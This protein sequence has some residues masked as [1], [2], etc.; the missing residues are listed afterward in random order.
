MK[1]RTLKRDLLGNPMYPWHR[2]WS[3]WDDPPMY[4]IYRPVCWLRG[5]ILMEHSACDARTG[6]PFTWMACGL[7]GKSVER[8]EASVID[9]PRA[10]P[11]RHV[12]GIP[13]RQVRELVA[14]PS[15]PRLVGDMAY[16]GEK[17]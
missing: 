6:H 14:A 2:Y 13:Q 15:S 8:F 1:I 17:P 11:A 7:C 12:V 5:H 16:T 4:A 9:A 10:L 3:L